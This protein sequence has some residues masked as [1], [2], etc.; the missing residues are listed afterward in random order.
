M[1][2]VTCKDSYA[3]ILCLTRRPLKRRKD[4]AE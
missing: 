1:T 4:A 3:Y 2:K